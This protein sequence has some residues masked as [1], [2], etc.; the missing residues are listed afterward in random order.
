MSNLRDGGLFSI[1]VSSS[2]LRATYAKSLRIFLSQ[3]YAVNR[4]VDFGG[5]A[6]FENAKDTYVCIPTLS[7]MAPLQNLNVCKVLSIQSSNLQNYVDENEYSIPVTHLTPEAWSIDN[8]AKLNLF[9]KIMAGG[10]D[11]EKYT[12]NQIFYG[13]KTGLNE[14]FVIDTTTKD[15]LISQDAKSAEIIK[16]LLQGEDIRDWHIT[17]KDRWIIFTRRGINIDAYPAIKQHLTQWKEDL[18]PK[19]DKN[20]KRGRKPGRYKWYEIQYIVN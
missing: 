2:F 6:I 12:G 3:N 16:P 11:L 17:P 10:I 15:R 8:V 14:A 19:Q 13:I 18:T 9:Q 7:R 5:L 20:Q 1:I 4:I